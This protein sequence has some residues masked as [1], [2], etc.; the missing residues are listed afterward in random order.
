MVLS[1]INSSEVG[2]ESKY[3]V[4]IVLTMTARIAEQTNEI[5]RKQYVEISNEFG[6]LVKRKVSTRFVLTKKKYAIM[7]QVII[8]LSTKT[9]L[10]VDCITLI[11]LLNP[12]TSIQHE[13]TSDM[14]SAIPKIVKD[15]I[16]R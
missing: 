15:L 13:I 7:C 11:N 3:F 1:S 4:K 16:S 10:V 8:F 14:F 2:F 5:T 12:Q 6:N 9:T